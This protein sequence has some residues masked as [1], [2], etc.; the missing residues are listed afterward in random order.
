MRYNIT[1]KDSRGTLLCEWDEPARSLKAMFAKLG[2]TDFPE[3]TCG[4][5][6]QLTQ[7]P[8]EY[9]S[10]EKPPGYWFLGEEPPH[11]V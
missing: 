9:H 2:H 8:L 1:T 4:V 10:Q 7:L 5:T 11:D 6:V 3:G